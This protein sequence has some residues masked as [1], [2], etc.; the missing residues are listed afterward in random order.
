MPPGA[1]PAAAASAGVCWAAT[2][3]TTYDFFPFAGL[4][5]PVVLYIG[6]RRPH[7]DDVT[8][9]TE[10]DGADGVVTVA[11]RWPAAVRRARAS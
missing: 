9:V 8:V 4:H 3:A 1:P 7:I 6:A 10:I 2:R 5:R 11:R